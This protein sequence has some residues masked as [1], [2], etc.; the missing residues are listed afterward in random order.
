MTSAAL[1]S[2]TDTNSPRSK[3]LHFLHHS[4]TTR[5]DAARVIKDLAGVAERIWH[6]ESV[7]LTTLR[8][9][10][11]DYVM[12]RETRGD[13]GKYRPVPVRYDVEVV[14]GVVVLVRELRHSPQGLCELEKRRERAEQAL[15]RVEEE[16]EKARR[17][18]TYQVA[19]YGT[20]NELLERESR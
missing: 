17:A 5:P 3:P 18:P 2:F 12:L 8:L 9:P 20:L 7:D 11:V 16:M 13:A 4:D 1:Y 10:H 19:T 6:G 15:A 14:N